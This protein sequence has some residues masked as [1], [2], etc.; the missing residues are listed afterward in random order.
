VEPADEQLRVLHKTL[1]AVTRDTE[2]MHFNTAIARMMEYVNYFTRQTVRP[3]GVLEPFVLM[4]APYAPH[5]AEELWQLLG[6]QESLSH[7][8]WPK[9]DPKWSQDDTIE[10]PVQILGKLRARVTVPVGTDKEGLESA[11]RAEPRIEQILSEKQVIKVIAVPD[12]L[13][14]FVVK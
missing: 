14:N 4:L 9:L 8:P 6:H 7:H 13:V 11:A 5:L 12:R 2:A 1:E 3:R 10:I